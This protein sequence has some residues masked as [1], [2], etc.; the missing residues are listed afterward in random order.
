MGAASAHASQPWSTLHSW[1]YLKESF[2]TATDVWWCLYPLPACA[3]RWDRAEMQIPWWQWPCVNTWKAT[4]NTEASEMESAWKPSGFKKPQVSLIAKHYMSWHNIKFHIPKHNSKMLE[5]P[6]SNYPTLT[7][8]PFH[9]PYYGWAYLTH[10][11]RRQRPSA[12]A[13]GCSPSWIRQSLQRL[14][15]QLL[16]H[17]APKQSIS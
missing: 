11:V 1:R 10:R 17:G 2:W 5:V 15:A 7:S 8:L 12:S 3:D 6:A 16:A 14:R 13:V 9:S 4:G